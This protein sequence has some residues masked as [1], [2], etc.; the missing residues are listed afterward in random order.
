LKFVLLKFI[1]FNYFGLK[2]CIWFHVTG[3]IGV[4]TVG[5]MWTT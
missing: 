5:W 3:S 1:F 2:I 4:V